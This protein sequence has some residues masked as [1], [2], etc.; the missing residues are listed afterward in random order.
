M[1]GS[2]RC[3]QSVWV[4]CLRNPWGAVPHDSKPEWILVEAEMLLLLVVAAGSR[5]S[6]QN[7]GKGP[8]VG[9]NGL[10]GSLGAFGKQRLAGGRAGGH[11]RALAGW[12]WAGR[13]W[14]V[15]LCFLVC[16]PCGALTSTNVDLA[17]GLL[18]ISRW[19]L[20]RGRKQT[21]G[22]PQRSRQAATWFGESLSAGSGSGSGDFRF[23]TQI[24]IQIQIQIRRLGRSLSAG[25]GLDVSGGWL[26]LPNTSP[27]L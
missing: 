4:S 17:D 11:W 21:T 2:G 24:Q 26:Q 22:D 15:D 6:P 18:R 7:L 16:V 14:S 3:P 19:G 13:R 5:R 25:V 10:E 8:L 12:H 20:E 27:A 9:K 23:Q 1:A